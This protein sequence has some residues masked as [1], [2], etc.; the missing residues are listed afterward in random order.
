[1]L[2]IIAVSVL[3]GFSL[4]FGGSVHCQVDSAE[5]DLNTTEGTVLDVD[6]GN[7]KITVSAISSMTFSVNASANI[8]RDIYDIKLSDVKAGDYVTIGY[9]DDASGVHQAQSITV[10]YSKGDTGGWTDTGY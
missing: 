6:T 2:R 5:P 1:M 10:E 3:V 7:S 9:Y 4:F 8:T